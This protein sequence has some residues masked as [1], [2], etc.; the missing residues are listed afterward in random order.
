MADCG[1]LALWRN[2]EDVGELMEKEVGGG[3]QTC[4]VELGTNNLLHD[5]KKDNLID[6]FRKMF[7]EMKQQ[8]KHLVI[9]GILPRRDLSRGN[10]SKRL[11]INATLQRMCR[12]GVDF[13]D[14]EFNARRSGYL[15]STRWEQTWWHGGFY[16]QWSASLC[17]HLN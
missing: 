1:H 6:K 5:D 11:E 7:N 10:E 8:R 12:R 13:I 14:V 3:V 2:I 4:V 9:L 15:A 17:R 16:T